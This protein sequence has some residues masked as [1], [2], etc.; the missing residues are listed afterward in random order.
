[1]A[2]VRAGLD[3]FIGLYGASNGV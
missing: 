2:G 1:M 3:R